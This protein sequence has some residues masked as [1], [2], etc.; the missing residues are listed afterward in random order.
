MKKSF[1]LIELIVVITIIAILMAILV[2]NFPMGPIGRSATKS[3]IIKIEMALIE[4]KS[5]NG[6]YPFHDRNDAINL[7]DSTDSEV[8]KIIIELL[9]IE[10]FDTNEN[11][12]PIDYWENPIYYIN[13]KDYNSSSMTA[14]VP[15]LSEKVYYNPKTFQLVS[16][17]PDGTKTSLG[18][19][20]D[21]VANYPKN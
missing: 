20:E 2:P 6:E 9:K 19:A 17:G 7:S 5:R 21:N 1:T 14:S 10:S 4:Y 12:V 15:S 8:K 3:D 18:N 11:G 16:G 13:K